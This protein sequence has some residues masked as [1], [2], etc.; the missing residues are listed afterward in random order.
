MNK[1]QGKCEMDFKDLRCFLAVIAA[2]SITDAAADLRMS[3]PTLSRRI[4]GLEK[5]LGVSLFDR[6]GKQMVLTASGFGFERY[7]RRI[8]LELD[9]ARQE[10][11]V[12]PNGLS[13]ELRIGC[14]ESAVSTRLAQWLAMFQRRN[15]AVGFSVMS[16]T[17]QGIKDEL[18]RGE[19]ELGFVIE[20]VE[21]A[22]YEAVSLPVIDRWG[23]V[24]AAD[25]DLAERSSVGVDDIRGIPLVGP[26]REI[27][28]NQLNTWLGSDMERLDIRGS[29]GL[30]RNACEL[31]VHEG[32]GFLA[33]EGG[34]TLSDPKRMTFVPFSPCCTVGHKMIWRKNMNPGR[35]VAAFLELVT[36]RIHIADRSANSRRVDPC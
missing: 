16:G 13:G 5:H 11:R 9:R 21:S 15:P 7:A 33:I 34:V 19:L 3:Q 26:D 24:V 12:D 31:V 28:R 1:S 2:G 17:G 6:S 29:V 23:I 18:D 10:V 20:P 4:I 14:V 30:P 32:Y 8:L 36:E 35:T 22:K 27:V 25:S